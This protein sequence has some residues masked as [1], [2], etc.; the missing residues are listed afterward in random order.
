MQVESWYELFLLAKLYK[1]V[2]PSLTDGAALEDVSELSS[3]ELAMDHY[4][5]SSLCDIG[6][7]LFGLLPP[8]VP[9]LP[10]VTFCIP[11]QEHQNLSPAQILKS[12]EKKHQ[13][14]K[15]HK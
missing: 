10:W 7:Y 2:Q 6:L 4:D 13:V 11:P 9:F 14:L 12:Y 8:I 5:Y 3:L 15:Q 1:S